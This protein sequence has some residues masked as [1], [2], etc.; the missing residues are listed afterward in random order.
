MTM[1]NTVSK[2]FKV[3]PALIYSLIT[4]QAS[5]APKALLELVMNSVDAGATKVDIEINESG[6]VIADNG[7]GFENI[8]TVTSFFGTFGTPHEDGDA[9]YGRFRL[10]RAQSFGI[11]KTEWYSKDF[12]MKVDL[13]VDLEMDDKEAPLGYSVTEGHSYYQ[14]CKIVGEFYK[15]QDVGAVQDFYEASVGERPEE[16]PLIPALIK[17]IRYIPCEVFI[18][19]EKVSVSVDDCA[20][21]HLTKDASYILSESLSSGVINVYNKGVYAYQISS[22]YHCGDVVSSESLDLN[23]ARNEAKH[24]CRIAKAIKNKIKSIDLSMENEPSKKKSNKEKIVDISKFMDG[25]WL[26]LLGF[27]ELNLDLL[28]NQIGS[29]VLKLANDRKISLKDLASKLECIRPT[30]ESDKSELLIIYGD[31]LQ[32]V[33][34]NDLDSMT[35]ENYFLPSSFFPSDEILNLLNHKVELFRNY[36]KPSYGKFSRIIAENDGLY[37]EYLKY[38]TFDF[39]DAESKNQKYALLIA[40]FM[41][42]MYAISSSYND[43]FSNGSANTLAF[44]PYRPFA[45]AKFQPLKKISFAVMDIQYV[46]T[47]TLTNKIKNYIKHSVKLNDIEKMVIATLQ[48]FTT[49]Q[50]SVVLTNASTLAYT[51][52]VEN[53]C[54]NHSFL[55]ECIKTGDFENLISV[56]IHEISHD[57][58]SF[59]L[60]SHGATFYYNYMKKFSH[61]F[62]NYV[63]DFYALLGQ[64]IERRVQ[65]VGVKWLSDEINLP[66]LEKIGKYRMLLK[67]QHF[68]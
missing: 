41:S 63:N 49:R 58:N 64:K 34:G 43:T 42:A 60:A 31:D 8:E 46:E 6:F 48:S 13:N 47:E 56:L 20:V 15:N 35:I 27:Q 23:I 36:C 62:V 67:I 3:H 30:L 16:M 10:G 51:D 25:V 57:S 21:S 59:H 66:V 22:R 7:N 38:H 17:M 45:F 5:G 19:N 29:K 26:S 4:K 12:C 28:K 18:N 33:D 54:F 50:I 44:L 24:N 65:S 2:E 14:G 52:G 55:K 1:Q 37:K 40:V 53:I 39:S 68:A 11:A 9:Y 61:S 32:G